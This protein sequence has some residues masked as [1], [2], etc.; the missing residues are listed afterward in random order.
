MKFEILSQSITEN[1]AYKLNKK[2]RCFLSLYI[3]LIKEIEDILKPVLKSYVND[4]EVSCKQAAIHILSN[5]NANK[6]ANEKLE[7]MIRLYVMVNG[8][9][10]DLI[11]GETYTFNPEDKILEYLEKVE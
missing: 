4:V 10:D 6:E 9:Q 11:A 1:T 7:S 3:D 8:N 2:G 5:I